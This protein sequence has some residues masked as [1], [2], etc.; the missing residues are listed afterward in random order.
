MPN[1]RSLVPWP[2][3]IDLRLRSLGYWDRMALADPICA[4]VEPDNLL[5]GDI[6]GFDMCE[7]L[8]TKMGRFRHHHT[9]EFCC[10]STKWQRYFDT[11]C[12]KKYQML[13]LWQLAG[14]NNENAEMPFFD[15]LTK[16]RHLFYLNVERTWKEFCEDLFSRILCCEKFREDLISRKSKKNSPRENFSH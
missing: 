11:D 6:C 12:L 16:L 7:T 3:L 15:I 4:L 5:F 1:E 2:Y 13:I 14:R 9:Y 10:N 8:L